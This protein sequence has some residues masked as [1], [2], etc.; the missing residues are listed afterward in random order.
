[1]NITIGGNS[2]GKYGHL[3]DGDGNGVG[4]DPFTLTVKTKVADVTAPTVTDVYP[5]G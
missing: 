5:S 1:M 2:E 4:G 3:F